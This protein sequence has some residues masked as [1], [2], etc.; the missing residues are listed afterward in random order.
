MKRNDGTED[1]K[2]K[3][4]NLLLIRVAIFFSI[5]GIPYFCV[6]MHIG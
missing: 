3:S 2:E 5:L 1:L 4:R 6:F